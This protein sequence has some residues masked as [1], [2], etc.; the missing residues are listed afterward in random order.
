MAKGVDVAVASA[1]RILAVQR[2]RAA[3]AI[4]APEH[5]GHQLYLVRVSAK[6]NGFFPAELVAH[7]LAE[8]AYVWAIVE[9]AKHIRALEVPCI[10]KIKPHPA[11]HG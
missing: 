9:L 10:A 2:Y 7:K 3:A 4:L 6:Y 5:I 1:E 11:Y 8:R